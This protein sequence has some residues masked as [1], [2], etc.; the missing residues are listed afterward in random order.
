MLSHLV[1]HVCVGV[2]VCGCVCVRVC[3][4]AHMYSLCRLEFE[5]GEEWSGQR[6]VSVSTQEGPELVTMPSR[7]E[8]VQEKGTIDVWWI[9]D[10]GG[11]I[12][13]HV[14]CTY[15]TET[16]VVFLIKSMISRCAC[17]ACQLRICQLFVNF[18]MKISFVSTFI[19]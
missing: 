11:T 8:K 7:F 6:R 10:D 19:C 15:S 5:E 16:T 3:M 2:W 18:Y 14:H 12:C 1:L 4:L 9:Y 13:M 17:F